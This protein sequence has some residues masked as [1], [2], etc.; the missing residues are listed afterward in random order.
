[1]S[2]F[3]GLEFKGLMFFPGHFGVPRTAS[4]LAEQ[5]NEFLDRCFETFAR[6]GL[7]LRDRERRLDAEPLTKANCFMA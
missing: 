1:M 4:G 2:S 6:A 3:P 7:P 5:V